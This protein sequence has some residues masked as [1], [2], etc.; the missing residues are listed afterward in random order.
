MW[1]ATYLSFREYFE[2]V[3]VTVFNL[4]EEALEINLPFEF[5]AKRSLNKVRSGLLEDD[6]E[7]TGLPPLKGLSYQIFANY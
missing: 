6:M 7:R 2:K 5:E 4:S 1:R 3:I